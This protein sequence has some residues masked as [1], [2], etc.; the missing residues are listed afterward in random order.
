MVKFSWKRTQN[1]KPTKEGDL[2][3]NSN[4]VK[5]EDLEGPSDTCPPQR[6]LSRQFSTNL[7]SSSLNISM[8][9]TELKDDKK[10]KYSFSNRPKSLQ[11]LPRRLPKA[12]DEF[13]NEKYHEHLAEITAIFRK[14]V[15]IKSLNSHSNGDLLALTYDRKFLTVV[16]KNRKD[17][18]HKLTYNSDDFPWMP[19]KGTR[20]MVYKKGCCSMLSEA[21]VTISNGDASQLFEFK[22]NPDEI[23]GLVHAVECMS[24]LVYLPSIEGVS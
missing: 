21:I 1:K 22:C 5:T 3:A 19:I 6:G 12:E 15:E 9:T 16:P 10:Y 14:G 11:G 24:T 2:N 13:Y 17:F 8:H 7:V 20:I 4:D 23:K 18:F